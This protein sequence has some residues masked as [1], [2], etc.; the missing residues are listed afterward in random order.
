MGGQH[1]KSGCLV[2]IVAAIAIALTLSGV[3]GTA[4]VT[5][6]GTAAVTTTTPMPAP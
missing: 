5:S 4:I 1:R 6:N 3:V 2:Y